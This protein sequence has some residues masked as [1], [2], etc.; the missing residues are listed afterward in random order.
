[1]QTLAQ[2]NQ[3]L[4]ES[5][6]LKYIAQAYGEIAAVKLQKIRSG[7][8]KNRVFFQDVTGVY[9]AV[10]VAAAKR[11]I[12]LKNAKKRGTVSIIITSN[13]RF[14]GTLEEQLIKYFIVNTTKFRTDRVVIGKTALE[15][16]NTMHYSHPYQDMI[17]KEDLPDISE[18]RNLIT[19]LMDYEQ[20]LVYYSRMQ[21]VMLQ[22]PHVVDILQQPPEHYQETTGRGLEYIFE[23]ELDK[24]LNF[25]NG[26][27]ATLLFEQTF[28]ESELARTAARLISMN[29]AQDNAD[30]LIKE[31]KI[32]LNQAKRSLDN[33]RLLN[34]IATILSR[35]DLGYAI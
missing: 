21:S 24:V 13:H 16:L 31:Q 8:E 15:F 33:T 2:I 9:R 6:S 10:R 3:S 29:Q 4:D 23:P 18:L 14:Y 22:E 11:N 1:M 35:R 20:I 17:F 7:I 30:S 12:E 27:I 34:T 32:S 26:Q 19:N 28:L 5:T 25:F